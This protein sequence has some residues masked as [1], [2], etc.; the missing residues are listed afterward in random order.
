MGAAGAAFW[1]GRAQV[2]DL[3]GNAPLQAAND[4]VDVGVEDDPCPYAMCSVGGHV[5]VLKTLR[6][7]WRIQR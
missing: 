1:G 3:L 6:I 2:H 5:L 7:E 4:A